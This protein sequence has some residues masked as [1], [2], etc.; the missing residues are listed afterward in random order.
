MQGP[1]RLN[2]VDDPARIKG[3]ATYVDTPDVVRRPDG[4]QLIVAVLVRDHDTACLNAYP[5][6]RCARSRCSESGR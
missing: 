6:L 5:R 4:I 2:L 3:E 1:F